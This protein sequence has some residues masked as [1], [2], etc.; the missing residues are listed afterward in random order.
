M[1]LDVT[2]HKFSEAIVTLLF[3]AVAF[4][5]AAVVLLPETSTIVTGSE[6][7][8][9]PYIRSFCADHSLLSPILLGL[10]YVYMVLRL[11]R[12]TVRVGLYPNTTL[13][14]I[15]LCSV[16]LFGALASGDYA[17]LCVGALLVAEAYGRLLYCF[18]P[19]LH[20]HYLFSAMVT[21]G[22]LPLVDAA[23]LPLSILIPVVV[24]VFRA[25][26]RETAITLFGLAAP[27]FVYSYVMWLLGGDFVQGFV[28]VWGSLLA[29]SSLSLVTYLTLP[30]LVFLG[31]I[32]FLQLLSVVV[33]LTTP[34]SLANGVREVWR[35][36]IISV[37]IL[38]VSLLLLPAASPSL[39]VAMVLLAAIMLPILMQYASAL[40]SVLAYLLLVLLT[41]IPLI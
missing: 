2:R 10:L 6:A 1:I 7:P 20:V 38:V 25:T 22:A 5:I 23:F 8:L 11:S 16:L 21:F 14:A 29:P 18:S 32:L 31:F 3:F 26:L 19:S 30:R 36:L 24:V 33:Y 27:T 4:A 28:D 35:V 17:M 34:M 12:S 37:V 9:A 13:A 15:A 41:F 40:N 39:I